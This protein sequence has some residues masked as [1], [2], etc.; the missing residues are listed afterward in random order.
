VGQLLDIGAY[1]G[2]R[3]T[4]SAWLG[5]AGG[6]TA[7]L[8]AHIIG[9]DGASL[10]SQQLREANTQAGMERRETD[11]QVPTKIDGGRLVIY[12]AVEG[13]AGN[14]YFDGIKIGAADVSE[15]AGKAGQTL[16]AQIAI[17]ARRVLRRIP[18]TL[19]GTNLEWINNGNDVWD[20]ATRAP[21]EDVVTLTRDLG[22][23]LIRFPGGV[24]SDYYHWRDGVGDPA[25]RPSTLH[26]PN[27]PKSQHTFG[28]DETLQFARQVGARLLITVNAGTGTAREA[29]DWVTYV[30]GEGGTKALVDKTTFWE[31]GNELYMKDDLSGASMPPPRYAEIA[32]SFADEMRR[33]DPGIKI[34]AI[35]GIN[36]G[37]YSFVSY[38][39]WNETVLS[40]TG[41]KIDFL[42]VHNAYAPLLI[43]SQAV[44]PEQV[45]LALLAAPQLIKANLDALT[46]QI[47]ATAAA[48]AR[49]LFLAVTEWG[50]FFDVRPSSEWVDH[51]KTLGSGLYVAEVLRVFMESPRVEVANFFKLTEPSFMGWMGPKNG[52]YVP[53]APYLAF[54]LYRK[55]FGNVLIATEVT[56]PVFDS[57]GA[58]VVG[59][60]KD[61]PYLSAVAALDEQKHALYLMI[62]NKHFTD[63]IEARIKLSGLKV[64]QPGRVR[65]LAGSS[66]D[67]HTGTG[68][69]EI[70]GIAWG[71]Q[72]T[73]TPG[74]RFDA[75]EMDNVHVETSDLS[76]IAAE[77][78]YRL[79]PHSVTNLEIPYR[80]E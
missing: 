25:S 20:P 78:R 70:P 5:A 57:P 18:D 47:D 40:K 28:T 54:Q 9:K 31:I 49:K 14:A 80:P 39:D 62:V 22:V 13:T 21:R 48:G 17:D 33:A 6:A 44:D 29:A 26:Y 75:P 74:T 79:T 71:Q 77:F 55:H 61:V 56:S 4:L 27:G 19:Y 16:T 72:K 12:C 51:V 3:L 15:P 50:P 52:R 11:L 41:D 58:G 53:K 38:P 36:C 8:G 30:N 46:K 65:I 63:A 1:A 76:N 45:Y 42:A 2:K 66:I 23:T 32:A 73:V 10:Q 24:L 60:I 35:G 43:N 34:G 59:P 68:L 69:P 67:A 37:K 64:G 7:V